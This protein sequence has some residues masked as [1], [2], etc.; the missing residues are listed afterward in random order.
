MGLWGANDRGQIG[1]N[2]TSN[3]NRPVALSF[4]NRNIV[5][6]GLRYTA[7]L[8]DEGEVLLS[9]R[10]VVWDLDLPVESADTENGE[11][12]NRVF[13]KVIT[14][15]TFDDFICAK[16]SVSLIKDNRIVMGTNT[17]MQVRAGDMYS[18]YAA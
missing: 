11:L 10:G 8:T 16:E 12:E 4:K 17:G 2:G 14:N 6:A 13:T 7:A 15:Q 9:G 18:E 1:N 3:T 5:G